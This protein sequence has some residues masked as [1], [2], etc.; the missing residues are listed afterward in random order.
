MSL[1]PV[2]AHRS[3]ASSVFG[4][5]SNLVRFRSS[6][7]RQKR[8]DNVATRSRVARKSWQASPL[9]GPSAIAEDLAYFATAPDTLLLAP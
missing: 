7:D 3:K 4:S 2:A 8:A 6:G 1:V 9:V 5:G